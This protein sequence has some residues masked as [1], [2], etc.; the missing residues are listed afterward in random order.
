M[1]A[2]TPISFGDFK[3]TLSPVRVISTTN[4]VGEY[5][6]GPAGNG[7]QA[8][9]R[10]DADSLTVDGVVLEL[11]DRV[12][13][14]GQTATNQNGIYFLSCIDYTNV[15]LF[16]QRA[17]DQQSLSQLRAG[18][19]T[20]AAAGSQY[21]GNVFSLIEPLP[22]RLGI[23]P[24]KWIPGSI[25]NLQPTI[26]QNLGTWDAATNMTSDGHQLQ[27]SVGVEGGF[28]VVSVAGNTTLNGITDWQVQQIALFLGGKWLK[29]DLTKIYSFQAPL[30]LTGGLVTFDYQT[31]K[32]FKL[33][34]NAFDLDYANFPLSEGLQYA[35]L[36]QST[37][38][39]Q[40][41]DLNY[42]H[43]PTWNAGNFKTMGR[44]AFLSIYNQYLPAGQQLPENGNYGAVLLPYYPSPTQYTAMLLIS[45][46]T[47]N[48]YVKWTNRDDTWGTNQYLQIYNTNQTGLLSALTTTAKNTLVAAINENVTNIGPLADLGTTAKENLVAAINE[49]NA[50]IPTTFQAPLVMSA[51]NVSLNTDTSLG[52]TPSQQLTVETTYNS[53][54]SINPTTHAV[55]LSTDNS[56]VVAGSQLKNATN[57]AAPLSINATTQQVTLSTDT[58]LKVVGAS[59]SSAI[60]YNGPLSIN[61]GQQVSLNTDNSLGVTSDNKLQVLLGGALSVYANLPVGTGV[62]KPS[63]ID[64]SYYSDAA[65][66]A[67][68][69]KTMNRPAFLG[70]YNQYL[71]PDQQLPEDG[72]YGSVIL[73]YQTSADQ[74]LAMLMINTE[75]ANVYVKWTAHDLNWGTNQYVQIYNTNQTG[76][77]SDLTTSN[78]TTLVSAINEINSKAGS[79]AVQDHVVDLQHPSSP[80]SAIQGGAYGSF[81]YP[82]GAIN[83]PGRGIVLRS[84]GAIQLSL[85]TC[86]LTVMINGV[87]IIPYSIPGN[88]LLSYLPFD[89]EIVHT[90]ISPG[91][92]GSLNTF[93]KL[94]VYGASPPFQIG[95]QTTVG[96]DMTVS[97]KLDFTVQFVPPNTGN[98]LTF[99]N[100]RAEYF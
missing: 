36:P 71:S 23:D 33:T 31:G 81:T 84:N 70:M 86:I 25:T 73:P 12:L 28:Y 9:L 50:R 42:Y 79:F 13:L 3:G 94:I 54:L 93:F 95:A 60:T 6:N 27:S 15:D 58:S 89:L 29:Y 18:Q 10:L 52:L 14:A 65:F 19:F 74:H 92:S 11:G 1:S 75:S 26:I 55:S 87:S 41:L 44:P 56:L 96:F 7:V 17:Q 62:T 45:T 53:P 82:A 35:N 20:F 34:G 38:T 49:I 64:L 100:F 2:C 99:N 78:K 85:S 90:C 16:L 8:T 21:K 77:T 5:D 91:S 24:I 88:I 66:N 30:M 68:N 97:G 98:L 39:K 22:A 43:N 4:I 48:S 72:K 46:Q 69:F 83:A 57:Y 76:K 59:L 47:G 63:A 32:G 40:V 61:S 37:G 80:A 67:T 51:G